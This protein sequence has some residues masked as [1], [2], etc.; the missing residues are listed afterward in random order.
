MTLPDCLSESN[1]LVTGV[2]HKDFQIPVSDIPQHTI[3]VNVSEFPNVNEEELMHRTD[4]TYIPQVGKVT[5]AIL[6][7]NLVLLHRQKTANS[8]KVL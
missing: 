4:I 1:I 7:E 3:V 5:V 2:P 8:D 6:E